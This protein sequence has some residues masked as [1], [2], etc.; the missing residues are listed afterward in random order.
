[1]A[2]LVVS[3]SEHLAVAHGDH[4]VRVISCSQEVYVCIVYWVLSCLQQTI[5]HVTVVIFCSIWLC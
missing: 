1:L 3:I 4:N 2:V 5:W